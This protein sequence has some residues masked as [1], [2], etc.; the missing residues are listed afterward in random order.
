MKLPLGLRRFLLDIRAG[1]CSG[2]PNCC[3]L[4]YAGPWRTFYGSTRESLY[5]KPTWKAKLILRYHQAAG[6]AG[7]VPC[8]LC[9]LS[10]ARV[11]VSRCTDECGHVKEMRSLVL[12]E[13][14]TAFDDT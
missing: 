14:P 1:K 11:R 12:E 4:F 2:F 7:Y 6:H 3:I 10:G 13:D 9:L 8:P 5:D